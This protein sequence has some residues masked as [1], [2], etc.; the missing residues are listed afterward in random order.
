MNPN[1]LL[2]L[3]PQALGVFLVSMGAFGLTTNSY[4]M[5]FFILAMGLMTFPP[6]FSIINARARQ[7]ITKPLRILFII[8]LFMFAMGVAPE[9]PNTSAKQKPA[10]KTQTD[11]VEEKEEVRVNTNVD[12]QTSVEQLKVV[13]VTDGDTFRVNINGKTVPVRLIGYDAPELSHPTEPKQC[14]GQESKKA[15]ESLLLNKQIVMEKD[16]S[17][18]DKYNRLLR[19]VWV[20]EVLINEYMTQ[21]GFGLA[22]AYPPDTKYQKRIDAGEESAKSALRGLWA[23]TTCN[24]NL[25]TGT[26]K[27]PNISQK[28]PVQEVKP[29]P[30]TPPVLPIVT[31]TQPQEHMEDETPN[32]NN[33]GFACNCSKT[34]TQMSSCEEAQYQLSSCGCS[35][36]DADGDGIACDSMCQ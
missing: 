32:N 3:I 36:R 17:D 30:T 27:D 11:K 9:S 8:V 12:P 25:Y 26:Y 16:K 35:A 5:A 24:G 22:S 6:T 18:K 20:G 33:S 14:F 34:C 1:R 19:Y 21:N 31:P 28:K 4:F 7:Q 2:N 15:L 13:S 29:T 10:P 23:Q